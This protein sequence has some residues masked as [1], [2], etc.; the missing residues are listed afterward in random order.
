MN[1]PG[2]VNDIRS[3]PR[4]EYQVAHTSQNSATLAGH[5]DH[6]GLEVRGQQRESLKQAI[7]G[8]RPARDTRFGSSNVACVF[9][10]SCNNRT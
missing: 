9:A 5:P 10:R 1:V 7:T 8:T 2:Y 3:L 6:P 4:S